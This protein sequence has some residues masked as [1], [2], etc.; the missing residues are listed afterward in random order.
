MNIAVGIEVWSIY[1]LTKKHPSCT[2]PSLHL[3]LRAADEA[4]PYLR[5]HTQRLQDIAMASEDNKVVLHVLAAPLTCLQVTEPLSGSDPGRHAPLR[6]NAKLHIVNPAA[7]TYLRKV[8]KPRKIGRSQPLSLFTPSLALCFCALL[9]TSAHTHP[10][11]HFTDRHH[12]PTT[13]CLSKNEDLKC[14]SRAKYRHTQQTQKRKNLSPNNYQIMRT[15]SVKGA[16]KSQT[17]PTA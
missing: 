17:R 2:V 11:S 10:L 4:R 12:R 14:Q 1:S 6:G 9:T 15:P 8:Q 13:P 7:V 5:G 3:F 16:P